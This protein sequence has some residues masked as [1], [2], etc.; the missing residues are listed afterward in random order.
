MRKTIL[1]TA[2]ALLMTTMPAKAQ[3]ELAYEADRHFR[4]GV[5]LLG[6]TSGFLDA[7]RDGAM[8]LAQSTENFLASSLPGHFVEGYMERFKRARLQSRVRYTNNCATSDKHQIVDDL[9]TGNEQLFR[10][11]QIVHFGD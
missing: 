11:M 2:A 1:A 9:Q 8:K 6:A 10:A 3:S 4:H 5:E 7:C